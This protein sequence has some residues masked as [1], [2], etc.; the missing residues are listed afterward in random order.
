MY[1]KFD[2]F[3]NTHFESFEKGDFLENE[4]KIRPLYHVI[5]LIWSRSSYYGLNSRISTLLRMINNMMI[6]DSSKFL[7]P[8]SLFQGEPDESLVTLGKVIDVLRGYKACF[9]EYRDKLASFV[10]PGKNPILWTFRPTDIFERFDKYLD[11][12][13]VIREIFVTANE[14]YKVEKIEL[15]G[16]KGR[17]L[18]RGIQEVFND[19]K[20]I[21]I[22]WT[23]IQFDPLDPTPKVNLFERERKVYQAETEIL[24][25]TLAA[26]LVQAFE[27][28]FTMESLIKL[29]EICG[30]LLQRPIVYKEIGD[31][32]QNLTELWNE[33]LDMIKQSFDE[34]YEMIKTGGF[35]NLTVDK[36]FP[37]VS[38]A[39]TWTKKLRARTL[40]PTEDLPNIEFKEIFECQE[41][42]YT[43]ERMKEMAKILDAIDVEI[44]S[45][46]KTKVPNEINLNMRK[47]LLRTKEDGLLDL[48]FDPALVAALKEVKL[49]K[50]MGKVDIPD[51]ALEL[52][53][54]SN[55]LWTARI[56]LSRIVD[57]YNEIKETTV[58]CEFEIIRK[59]VELIDDKLQI[60]LGSARW[61]DYEEVYIIDLHGDIQSL[62]RR[63][64][65]TKVN[66]EKILN[67]LRSWGLKPMYLRH[68]AV[69]TNL[70]VPEEF[71]AMI[72]K[73]QACCL[74]TKKLIDEMMDENFR[75]FFNLKLK[76]PVRFKSEIS[77]KK[78][79]AESLELET[80]VDKEDAPS[81]PSEID[82]GETDQATQAP[83]TGIYVKPIKTSST[84]ISSV[85]EVNFEIHPTNEQLALFRPYEEYI[86]L[87][88]WKEI[89]QSF[90]ISLKYIKYEMENRY[91]HNAPLFEVLLELQPPSIVFF[92]AMV[93]DI[94]G[95]LGEI[96]NMIGK[97]KIK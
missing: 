52:F 10:Q 56:M 42:V 32:L 53:E 55:S 22:K 51:V 38:G 69:N 88:I 8:G 19:F 79:I 62:H 27:E 14:F 36:G 90:Y 29:I 13:E 73:R 67:S 92:P 86:D 58:P 21:Y 84:S 39:L 18:S 5:C 63:T 31:K 94:R 77:R 82:V 6:E 35:D 85:S 89:R 40:K 72:A 57:W 95:L 71:P 47:Y 97:T 26:I 15:G 12:L 17:N 24:E 74:E 30:S 70:M 78:S 28:C 41:G 48:N 50:T 64:L 34:G 87:N 7:D 1:S 11:R 75:L 43:T 4:E 93:L 2:C 46:W 81:R 76:P 23:Q 91:E 59:D 83:D 20:N 65:Q 45:R 16:L 80:S 44:Y 33:D 25:R 3:Q 61:S 37:P 96:T 49:L 9:F 54:I 60:A 66:V 68:D